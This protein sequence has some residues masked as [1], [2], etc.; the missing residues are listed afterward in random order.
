MLRSSWGG[1]GILGSVK[2]SFLDP[3]QSYACSAR[4]APA[5]QLEQWSLQPNPNILWPRN[6]GL[7]RTPDGASV[8]TRGVAA[9]LVGA[10][11][12]PGLGAL[13]ELCEFAWT[14]ARM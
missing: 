3:W 7:A 14:S 9:V 8:A 6:H 13:D 12:G 4:N 2:D 1:A 11:S 10:Q 5:P